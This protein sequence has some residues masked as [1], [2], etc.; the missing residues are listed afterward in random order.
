MKKCHACNKDLSIGREV[1]R[2]D[3][4]P[5]CGADVRCC[6]NCSFYDTKVSKQC[7]EPGSEL[8]KDKARSNFCDYFSFSEIN[9]TGGPQHDPAAARRALDDLFKK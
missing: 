4:C 5:S 3:V 1:N 9:A 2:K 7:R 8:V 6:L